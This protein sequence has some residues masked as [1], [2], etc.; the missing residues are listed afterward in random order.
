M[1][2]AAVFDLDGLLIDT[3]EMQY[4]G[5]IEI[6]K[7]FGI[8][9]TEKDYISYVGNTAEMNEKLLIKNYGIKAE[10]GFLLE[11]RKKLMMKI[12]RTKPVKLMPYARK[13]LSFFQGLGVKMAVATNGP[14]SEVLLK[15]KRAG[16][17]RMFSAVITI[18]DVERGKPFPDTYLRAAEKLRVQPEECVAFEDAEIGVESAKAAGMICIAVPTR[19]SAKQD[20]SKA[21]AV[22]KNLKEACVWAK[23]EHD[24]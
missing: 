17:R 7:P 8:T 1:L 6:L 14:K 18:D 21:D 15:L 5:W 13:S 11:K 22:L 20:F 23:K 10:K 4:L 3:E 24:L 12:F 16:I 19:L 2:R 9:F